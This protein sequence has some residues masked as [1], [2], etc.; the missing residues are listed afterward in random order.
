MTD[1][2]LVLLAITLFTVMVIRRKKREPY[3]RYDS[4]NTKDV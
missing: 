4:N 2:V 3:N 1:T